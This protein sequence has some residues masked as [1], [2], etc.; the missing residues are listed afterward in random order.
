MTGNICL[1]RKIGRQTT[2]VI[3]RYQVYG[4]DG[5]F[6]STYGLRLGFFT[7]CSLPIFAG[8]Q[9]SISKCLTWVPEQLCQYYRSWMLAS[10]VLVTPE[11]LNQKIGRKEECAYLIL[12][13][14]RRSGLWRPRDLESWWLCVT[15]RKSSNLCLV[16][17]GYKAD[18]I[19]LNWVYCWKC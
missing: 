4:F 7:I 8:E 3:K 15:L 17:P 14:L 2:M 1:G 19:V 12:P 10:R 9:N 5:E 6:S 13:N 11:W 16:S 18:I